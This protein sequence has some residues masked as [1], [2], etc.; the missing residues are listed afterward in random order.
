MIIKERTYS[1]IGRIELIPQHE[2]V[3]IRKLPFTSGEELER[4]DRLGDLF[5][6]PHERE[7]VLLVEE[8]YEEV[9]DVGGHEL[10]EER[11]HNLDGAVRR[12]V[13][14]RI[15]D[16]VVEGILEDLRL[17]HGLHLAPCYTIDLSRGAVVH[18]Q[19]L[20]LALAYKPAG[21]DD[22]VDR[23]VD[24]YDIGHGVTVTDHGS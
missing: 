8:L 5:L 23:H 19:V 11:A 14:I 13:R 21:S 15:H 16:Y 10:L 18:E 9:H 12:K 20:T 6:N 24:R 2:Q 17:H 22:Q 4:I 3:I 7:R 1:A